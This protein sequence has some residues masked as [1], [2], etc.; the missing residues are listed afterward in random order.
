MFLEGNGAAGRVPDIES[1][2]HEFVVRKAPA[3]GPAF[4]RQ[5]MAKTVNHEY[6]IRMNKIRDLGL[7]RF[8][9]SVLADSH[10][11]AIRYSQGF[12]GFRVDPEHVFRHLLKKQGIVDRMPLGVQGASAK[13]QAEL[14]FGRMGRGCIGKK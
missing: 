4:H 6:G 12:G 11:A 13:C 7:N 9:I 8:R 5:G 1:A 2:L 14:S 3:H 10:G